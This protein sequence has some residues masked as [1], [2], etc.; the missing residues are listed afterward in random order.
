M[1]HYIDDAA[2]FVDSVRELKGTAPFDCRLISLC[3]TYPPALPFV[4]YWLIR[5][6]NGACT[7]AVA[8]N[9][10]AFILCLTEKSALP[11]VNAFLLMAGAKEVLC[12]D[13]SLDGFRRTSE[14]VILQAKKAA[15]G[16]GRPIIEPAIRDAYAV[17]TACAG[18][19][20]QPPAW[21]DFLV[22]VSH[23]LRHGAMRLAGTEQ[24]GGLA[25]VAM[26]VAEDEHSAV[27][28]AVACHPD[29]RRTGCGSAVTAHLV[30]ALLSEG[31]QVFVHRAAH[32]NA[33][34]YAAL[35]FEPVGMWREYAN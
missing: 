3:R 20:F 11:E 32:E 15:E 17:L 31:K 7:G 13:F 6:E 21:E 5:D 2:A 30:N 12:G 16:T 8:R 25:A 22:D 26:T 34:F 29:F 10:T 9:G 14:G 4:D 27:I 24:N 1:I 23:K 19:L 28:G 18:P 33:A 35:G